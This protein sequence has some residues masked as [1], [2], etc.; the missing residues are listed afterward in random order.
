MAW[1]SANGFVLFFV[2]WCWWGWGGGERIVSKKQMCQ[3]F[4]SQ[5]TVVT[6]QNYFHQLERKGQRSWFVKLIICA[7][8]SKEHNL[9]WL[10][11]QK[12]LLF[13]FLNYKA[14]AVFEKELSH[15]FRVKICTA[16][17]R[18]GAC[19]LADLHSEIHVARLLPQQVCGTANSSANIWSLL[20]SPSC[21]WNG[22]MCISVSKI[23]CWW[24]GTIHLLR[25]C[26]RR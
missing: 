25:K 20:F 14:N 18:T 13:M 16:F 7:D 9:A 19:C 22:S 12:T 11:I 6:S 15:W 26:P 23:C 5:S 1:G 24:G 4:S 8:I 21:L 10:Q 17:F 3:I 2:C